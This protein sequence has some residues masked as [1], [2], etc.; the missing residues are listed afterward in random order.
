M[1]FGDTVYAAATVTVIWFLLVAP[2]DMALGLGLLTVGHLISSL[3]A[4][5]ITGLIFAGKLAEARL[6]SIAKIW[7]L[8][9]VVIIFVDLGFFS[10]LNVFT[11][12]TDLQSVSSMT[13]LTYQR[14][15]RD[16]VLDGAVGFAGVYVGSLLRKPKKSQN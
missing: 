2:M 1:E 3:I 4:A 5:F 16:V 14:I 6:V 9:A 12:S 10:V 13:V 8:A 11:G 15:F 7:V